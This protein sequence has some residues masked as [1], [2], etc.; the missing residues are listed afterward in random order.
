MREPSF[1]ALEH[2]TSQALKSDA[3][4]DHSPSNCVRPASV[5]PPT[6]AMSGALPFCTP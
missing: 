6:S 1:W 5:P 2:T 3:R 4:S